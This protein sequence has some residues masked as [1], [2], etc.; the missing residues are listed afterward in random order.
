L[1]R[2]LAVGGALLALVAAAVGGLLIA[3]RPP[4]AAP[5]ARL[6][7]T[8]P[9]VTVV[10]PGAGRRAGHD[11]VVGDGRIQAIRPAGAPAA[12]AALEPYRGAFVLPGL[13]DLHTHLPPRTPLRLSGYFDLLYLA[14]GVTAVRDTGDTDG[15]AVPA[16]RRAIADGEVPGPRIFSCGPFLG[17]EPPRWRNTER[18]ASV[19]AATAAVER[20]AAAGFDCVKAYEDLS[21]DE[22]RAVV[23]AAGARGLRVIGH[24]PTELAYEE[25]LLPETQHFLGVPPPASLR[26]DHILDRMADWRAVDEARLDEIVR[27]TREHG[28]A[29]TPTL[30][31][32]HQILLYGDYDRALAD[33]VVGLLPRFFREVVWHRQRGNPLYADVDAGY[34]ALFAATLEKKKRL[35]HKLWQAETDLYLGTDT[36][37]PFVVPGASLHQEMRLFH[38]AGIP[39]EEVWEMATVRAAALLPERGLGQLAPGA[40]ADLLVFR[41]DPTRDLAALDSL[42]AVVAG[43]TL[44]SREDMERRMAAWQAHFAEPVFERLSLA[45]APWAIRHNVKRDW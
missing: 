3:L 13:I 36:L 11:L 34:L 21:S 28:L 12:P 39:P 7:F 17:G 26:R 25:A 43:G 32:A 10:Q 4:A 5:S 15:T 41:R 19:A 16:A 33:P 40:P 14:H 9:G 1:K 45:I 37:Q 20:I 42:E 44:L 18:V 2:W 29:N 22:L 27:V 23:A 6:G 24:V 38:A 8:L 35:V 31:L 30:V